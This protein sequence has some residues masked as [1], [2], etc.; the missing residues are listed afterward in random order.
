MFRECCL[1]YF[2]SL[3]L[4]VSKPWSV[5]RTFCLC[6]REDLFSVS[7]FSVRR[8]LPY[9]WC[10]LCLAVF[11]P[12]TLCWAEGGGSGLLSLFP[13]A[14]WRYGTAASW[15]VSPSWC[16]SVVMAPC[17]RGPFGL[18][19]VWDLLCQKVKGWSN[20]YQTN[21]KQQN[22]G[23]LFKHNVKSFGKN[24]DFISE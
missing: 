19:R 13:L 6:S 18:L 14:L 22:A 4:T 20:T 2:Y 11:S 10:Y 9:A 23:V 1:L 24:V 7:V 15:S 8:E 17:F 21:A 5:L 16:W 3:D 12:L